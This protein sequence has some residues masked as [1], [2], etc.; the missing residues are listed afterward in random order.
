MNI[1]FD[2]LNHIRDVT[3]SES[4]A[5]QDN[6]FRETTKQLKH[7]FGSVYFLNESSSKERVHCIT[8]K[9]DRAVGAFRKENNVIL[10][11]ISIVEAGL[12][13]D[14]SRRRVSNLIVSE[15][16]WDPTARRAIRILSIAPKPINLNYDINIW[17]KFDKHIDMIRYYI[18]SLFNPDLT[19][20]TC[21][22]DYTRAYLDSES[23]IGNY[24]AGDT[25][26]RLVQ[27]TISIRVETYMPMPKF[28]YTNTGEIKAFKTGVSVFDLNQNMETD[29]PVSIETTKEKLT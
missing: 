1:N 24:E 21:F 14:D 29:D 11:C 4:F 5:I 8:G 6:I 25:T 17:A 26:D 18:H 13:S 27:K 19:I 3:Q 20:N 7:I 2:V 10:P 9:Q 22:S 28:L 15:K 23:N 12:E 16:L